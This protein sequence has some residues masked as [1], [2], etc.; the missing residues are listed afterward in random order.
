MT[1]TTRVRLG[2][3]SGLLILNAGANGS[4]RLVQA[5]T[6]RIRKAIPRT[7]VGDPVLQLTLRVYTR[8][9]S[10]YQGIGVLLAMDLADDAY[11]LT[12]GLMLDA[13]RLQVMEREPEKA[14]ST[15]FAWMEQAT[16]DLDGRAQVA[17]RFGRTRFAASIRAAA[18]RQRSANR[19][20]ANELGIGKWKPLP[21]EGQNLASRA[22]RLDDL[23]D[24]TFASDPTHSVLVAALWHDRADGE[25]DVVIGAN[26]PSWTRAVANRA[27]RHMLRAATA[28]ATICGFPSATDLADY[29]TE[30]EASLDT[31]ALPE[32]D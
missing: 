22:G 31:E 21:V 17:D 7:S 16:K 20:V 14:L 6:N 8:L 26:Q 5:V 18:N 25:G 4:Y 29:A 13:Q 15:A 24:Y 11:A 32:A 1:L 28:T 27:T 19:A 2:P 30:V 23:F 9:L 3:M 12:R 10:R